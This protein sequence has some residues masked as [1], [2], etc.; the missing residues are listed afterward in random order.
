[1][2][3]HVLTILL[4]GLVTL[5]F[6]QNAKELVPGYYTILG[7]YSGTRE[8]YAQKYVET[9]KSKGLKADYGF[10]ASR[11]QYLIYVGY[12]PDLKGC[13]SDMRA[14]R[15]E[16]F[17]DAW[18]RVI[19]GIIGSTSPQLV[20]KGNEQDTDAPVSNTTTEKKDGYDPEYWQPPIKQYEQMKLSNTEVFLSMYDKQNNRIVDGNIQVIDAQTKKPLKNVNGNEYLYLPD[21]KGAGKLSLVCEVFGYKKIEYEINY[22]NPLADTV[23]PY[24]DLMGTTF[25]VSFDL[26]RAEKGQLG[27]LGRVYFYD[28][29]AIMTPDSEY[30]LNSLLLYMHENPARHV[31]LHGHTNGDYQGKITTIGP[32]KNFFAITPDCITKN[33]KAQEL[34]YERGGVIKEWLISKG[35]DA[36]RIDVKAWGGEKPL[37]PTKSADAQKNLRVEVE[38]GME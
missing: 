20:T 15:K 7:A 26:E 27:T 34:S 29:S 28:A 21:P 37:Y 8:A 10:N 33:G 13:L 18:V 30:D 12:F 4:C 3:K 38:V 23:K 24:V 36:K 14:K 5:S 35:V 16:G 17:P 2:K 6:A 9:L 19:P 11:D 25:V 31:T 32:S 1:M 22:Q